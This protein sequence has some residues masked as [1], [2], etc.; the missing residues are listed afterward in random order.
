M[1]VLGVNSS[2]DLSF[3]LLRSVSPLNDP[4]PDSP[5]A[6]PHLTHLYLIQNKLSKI[7]GVKHRTGLTY[8]EFGGNRIRVRATERFLLLF[9][10]LD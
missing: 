8:L 7:E 5:H 3:N 2:L 6:Y 1:R 4:S 10:Y 9:L